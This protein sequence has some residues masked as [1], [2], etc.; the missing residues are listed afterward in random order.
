MSRRTPS[1]RKRKGYDQALVTLTDAVTRKRRDYWLGPHGTAES[2][3]RYYRV[4]AEW[5]A[6]GRRLPPPPDAPVCRGDQPT[7]TEVIRGYWSWAKTYYCN[8]E[9]VPHIIYSFRPLK[10]L[11]SNLPAAEFGPVKLKAVRQK[12]IES[13]ICRTEINKRIGRVKRLFK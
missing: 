4:V 10:E 12:M 8:S 9:E 5:E 1:Y 6:S 11:Y 7:V 13:G 3:E 2:R